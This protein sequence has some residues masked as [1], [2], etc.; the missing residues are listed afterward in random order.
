MGDS[1]YAIW[2]QVNILDL[3]EYVLL[4]DQTLTWW[5]VPSRLRFIYN[6]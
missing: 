2:E 1:R 3:L 5:L 6:C 4:E